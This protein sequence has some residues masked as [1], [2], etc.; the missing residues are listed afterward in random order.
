MLGLQFV[1][2]KMLT[3]LKPLIGRIFEFVTDRT[4]HS[5]FVHVTTA[6]INHSCEEA[7]S[8]SLTIRSQI[9]QFLVLRACDDRDQEDT[10]E[11]GLLGEGVQWDLHYSA[12]SPVWRQTDYVIDMLNKRNM[13]SGL[14]T[15][16]HHAWTKQGA[17]LSNFSLCRGG[18]RSTLKQ[19]RA[20][21]TSMVTGYGSCLSFEMQTEQQRGLGS[22]LYLF[23]AG[24]WRTLTWRQLVW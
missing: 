7:G 14:A 11:S 21:L 3:L 24:R 18:T 16:P 20:S 9:A 4:I 6:E 17:T 8:V 13:H 1:N 23:N 2:R 15:T 19:A 5:S 10:E 12:D 22:F